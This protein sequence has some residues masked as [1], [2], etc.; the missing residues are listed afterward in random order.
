MLKNVILDTKFCEKKRFCKNLTRL[1][2]LREHLAVHVPEPAALRRDLTQGHGGGRQGAAQERR[3]L[4]GAVRRAR[5]NWDQIL[6]K[7]SLFLHSIEHF[8]HQFFQSCGNSY[9]KTIDGGR[10]EREDVGGVRDPSRGRR[11]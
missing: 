8:L 3:P 2:P 9:D 10:N 7:I 6:A 4:A 5:D 11:R 1:G